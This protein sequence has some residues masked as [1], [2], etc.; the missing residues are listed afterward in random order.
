MIQ[1]CQNKLARRRVAQVDL[2]LDCW[3]VGLLDC[4]PVGL[5]ACW[6]V[7]LLACWPVG[8]LV[9][10]S[11]GLLV[12]ARKNGVGCGSRSHMIPC[13][14]FSR[15]PTTPKH[16]DLT[17]RRTPSHLLPQSLS[18]RCAKQIHDELWTTSLARQYCR[19]GPDRGRRRPFCR[20]S[21]VG[22]GVQD[23]QQG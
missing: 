4:W 19:S 1:T 18:E 13:T 5:L 23:R 16:S 2:E 12:S 8:L 6:P 17:G 3:I 9:C 21:R 15:A 20:G 14:V 11:V 22:E 7:G 10:W